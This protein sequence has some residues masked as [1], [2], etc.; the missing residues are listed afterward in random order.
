M[1]VSAAP[2]R[3]PRRA[4]PPACMYGLGL[5]LVLGLGFE[6]ARLQPRAHEE[7]R[8]GGRHYQ[9]QAE[10]RERRGRAREQRGAARR[11]P[12]GEL[13]LGHLEGWGEGEGEGEVRVR[14]GLGL[15]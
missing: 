9:L 14:V 12:S 8:K 4:C 15:G 7:A 11:Q 2:A 3:P 6:H 13:R 10:G 1:R 5:G